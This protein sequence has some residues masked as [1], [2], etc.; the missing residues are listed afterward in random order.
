[1]GDFAS[2]TDFADSVSA[3]ERETGG[4]I[5]V[6][7]LDTETGVHLAHRADER[8]AMC[9][10]FKLMLAAAVL[11]R[12]DSGALRSSQRLRYTADN[13]LPNSSITAAH[14]HEGA[15]SVGVLAQAVVEVSD[16]T[17]ANLLLKLIGGPVGYTAYLRS[18]GD[19]LTRL[20]REE[21]ET[22]IRTFRAIR[23][24]PRRP[25]QCSRT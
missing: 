14:L 7:A 17:A 5:G 19:E 11:S 3:L 6:A 24:I 9:S 8:F 20:D 18:L 23:A 10:T 4:R 12:V 15:L 1:M 16:N 22:E 25:L 13:M 2:P 21:P